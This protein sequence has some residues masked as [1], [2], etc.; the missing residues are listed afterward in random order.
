MGYYD[1]HHKR[2]LMLT[3]RD[4]AIA[5]AA[6]EQAPSVQLVDWDRDAE[7]KLLAAICYSHT[8]LPETQLLQRVR[9]LD[10][11]IDTLGK[12][13]VRKLDP[14]VR[15]ALRLGAYQ[16]GHFPGWASG[17]IG[18]AAAGPDDEAVLDRLDHRLGVVPPLAPGLRVCP[19]GNG[20]APGHSSCGASHVL[21]PPQFFHSP[22]GN[23][24]R[25]SAFLAV[26][27]S[28]LGTSP[29]WPA[30]SGTRPISTLP[31]CPTC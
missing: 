28:A 25:W 2:P 7:D 1:A 13:P 12:R 14:P 22:G 11:A 15:A 5:D 19:L 23:S 21:S 31:T 30:S 10:H 20:S 29:T 27:I 16:I 3:L 8:N 26:A 24:L 6:L 4:R 17:G 18:R 9:T